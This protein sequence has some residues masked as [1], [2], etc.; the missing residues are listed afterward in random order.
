MTA[1]IVAAGDAA[2]ADF[3]AEYSVGLG[4]SFAA[5]AAAVAA[6]N[7]QLDAV[8]NT[9]AAALGVSDGAVAALDELK[10]QATTLIA[11]PTALGATLNTLLSA[12]TSLLGL[13]EGITAEYPGQANKI[14]SDTA[15]ATAQQLGALDVTAQPPYPGGPLHAAT[16]ASTAAITK[17]VRASSLIGVTNIF[18][19][20]PLESA[21]AAAQVLDTLGALTEQLLADPTTSDAL[22]AALTDLRAALQHHLGVVAGTLPTTTTYTPASSTPALLLAWQLHGDPTRDLEICARNGVLD[23]NFVLGG[24]P[25]EILGA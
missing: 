2:L 18:R 11:T 17:L 14:A 25:L 22:T 20:L 13:T 24:R 10:E 5:A 6:V 23:P 21:G 1:A 9:I 15:L 8:N 12:V 19:A 16:K 7:D 4:D 3:D